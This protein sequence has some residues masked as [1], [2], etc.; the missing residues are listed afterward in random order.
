MEKAWKH[1]SPGKG[2]SCSRGIFE[3]EATVS[4]EIPSAR[5]HQ[6]ESQAPTGVLFVELGFQGSMVAM[7]EENMMDGTPQV[8]PVDL[9]SS[10]FLACGNQS[11]KPCR[12]SCT[13]E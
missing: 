1:V 13:L 4:E 10:G 7:L 8:L 5:K 6:T 9:P 12:E 3:C 11:W 2:T